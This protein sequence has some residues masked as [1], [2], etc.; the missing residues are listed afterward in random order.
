MTDE[1]IGGRLI[2]VQLMI[3]DEVISIAEDHSR[4]KAEQVAAARA[5]EKLGIE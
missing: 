4:K 1:G 3:D 2:R 5:L